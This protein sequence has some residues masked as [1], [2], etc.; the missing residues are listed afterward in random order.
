M[1]ILIKQEGVR[2]PEFKKQTFILFLSSFPSHSVGFLFIDTEINR[3]ISSIAS[4]RA[5]VQ[6]GDGDDLLLKHIK[7][8]ILT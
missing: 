6:Y 2:G 3:T 5:Q 1:I 8:E 4:L 7:L